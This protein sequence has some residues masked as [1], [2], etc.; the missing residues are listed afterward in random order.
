MV[1]RVDQRR[2]GSTHEVVGRTWRVTP[3]EPDG[4][5][6]READRFEI[7]A[8][9]GELGRVMERKYRFVSGSH[10]FT[11]RLNMPGRNVHLVDPL[12]EEEPIGRL[13]VGSILAEF[14]RASQR[15]R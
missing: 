2:E 15:R 7:I 10:P 14:R 8:S 4:P 11:R 12:S 5:T 13:C 9:V 6:P 3:G 1:V